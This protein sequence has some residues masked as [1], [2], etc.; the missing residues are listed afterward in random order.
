MGRRNI[1]FLVVAPNKQ[2]KKK[3][4]GEKDRRK[5]YSLNTKIPYSLDTV[6]K[7]TKRWG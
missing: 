6:G 2:E 4:W 5:I 3:K 7:E 1:T